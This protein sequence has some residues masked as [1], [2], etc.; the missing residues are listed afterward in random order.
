MLREPTSYDSEITEDR[1]K[2][3]DPKVF[4]KLFPFIRPYPKILILSSI[5]VII[6]S[7]TVLGVGTGLRYFVDYGFSESSPLGLTG[8]ILGLFAV[9]IVMALASFGRLYWVS[10][11][12]ERVVADLRQAIFSH[13]LKLDVSFFEHTSLGEI[14]SRLTTD[15]TLLLIVMGGSDRHCPAEYPNHCGRIGPA[16]PDQSSVNRNVGLHYSPRSDSYSDLWKAG[17]T[18]FSPCAE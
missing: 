8:S 15:T 13:L 9:V 10:Q 14:Q 3:K 4:R 2:G 1:P 6:A 18:L 17:T 5:S 12:S 11:L 7:L 16:H